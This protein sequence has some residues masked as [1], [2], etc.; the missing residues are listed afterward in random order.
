[1]EEG[2]SHLG[3]L[4]AVVVRVEAFALFVGVVNAQGVSDFV[5]ED[6]LGV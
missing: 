1:M 4:S 2:D 5:H 3:Q 6:L